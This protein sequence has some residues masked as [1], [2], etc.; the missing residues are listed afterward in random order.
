ML[1]LIASSTHLTEYLPDCAIARGSTV[2][3]DS[4]ILFLTLRISIKEKSNFP[5]ASRGI[6]NVAMRDGECYLHN[7]KP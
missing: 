3:F 4:T 1:P 2:V 6:I 5:I 7:L